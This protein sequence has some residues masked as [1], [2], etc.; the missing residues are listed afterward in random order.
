MKKNKLILV[1]IGFIAFT[2]TVSAQQS[3]TI[4][5]S[6]L[7]SSFKFNDTQDIKL[8]SEYP[9]IYTSAYSIGYKYLMDNGIIF[10]GG[11]GMRNAGASLVYDDINYSWKLQY[12]DVKLG[13]G[14]AYKINKFSP[15]LIASGYYGYLLRG[16]QTLNNEDFNITESGILNRGDFGVILSPGVDFKLSDFI[17]SYLE[18][19]YIWGLN[20]IET[21]EG[22]K[23]SNYA[24]GLTLGLSF[25]ITS[26]SGNTIDID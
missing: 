14:Y 20:N 11:L 15:Y 6:Q 21:D 13:G 4:D 7:Y 24:M 25:T 10:R 3:L 17:S 23:A 8:N 2:L 5:A 26:S 22:Q 1:L 9:G 19:N 18:F 16:F 12:A